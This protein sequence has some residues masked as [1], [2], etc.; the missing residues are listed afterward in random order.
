M[1]ILHSFPSKSCDVY[2]STSIA[3]SPPIPSV[4]YRT[5]PPEYTSEHLKFSCQSKIKKLEH[6]FPEPH[7]RK[8][9][10]GRKKAWKSGMEEENGPEVVGMHACIS[11]VNSG[12]DGSYAKSSLP[13]P[14]GKEEQMQMHTE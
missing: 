10:L 12:K 8:R 9:D 14:K 4:P 2:K 13:S 7:H 3:P 11:Q 5:T 6:A 1:K